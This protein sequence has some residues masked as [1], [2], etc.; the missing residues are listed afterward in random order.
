MKKWELAY[1]KWRKLAERGYGS[2]SNNYT[3]MTRAEQRIRDAKEKY[4]K[5][6]EQAR[7]VGK[8]S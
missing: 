3:D 5:L 4:E 6:L 2:R 7:A 8:V 1:R